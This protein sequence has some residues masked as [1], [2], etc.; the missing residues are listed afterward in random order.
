MLFTSTVYSPDLPGKA[1]STQS[2]YFL[3]HTF[4]FPDSK[5]SMFMHVMYPYSNRICLSTRHVSGFTLVPELNSF[6]NIGNRAHVAIK[7]TKFAP[8]SV[9]TTGMILDF[10]LSLELSVVESEPQ[11]QKKMQRAS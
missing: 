10:F 6:G 9:L 4:F 1:T 2:R 8:C 7:H 11:I 5:L 3:I